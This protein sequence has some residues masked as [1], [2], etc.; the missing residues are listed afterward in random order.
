MWACSSPASQLLPK[1]R[2]LGAL[3]FTSRGWS[4]SDPSCRP[5]VWRKPWGSWAWSQAPPAAEGKRLG[6]SR[7]HFSPS[8][9]LTRLPTVGLTAPTLAPALHAARTVSVAG[10]QLE[11][12]EPFLPVRSAISVTGP[13]KQPHCPL[14][15][16]GLIDFPM[17]CE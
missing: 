2:V 7:L 12:Q 17:C 9:P 6:G 4:S 10:R 3:L 15:R 14:P 5:A 11:A 16:L 13:S 8:H 1:P